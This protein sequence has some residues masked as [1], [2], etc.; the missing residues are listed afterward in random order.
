M[1][2]WWNRFDRVT[3]R[4]DS[5]VSLVP[6]TLH[7]H[8]RVVPCRR[9]TRFVHWIRWKVTQ[10]WLL[11]CVDQLP[12]IVHTAGMRDPNGTEET[13]LHFG[14]LVHLR[15]S[16]DSKTTIQRNKARQAIL[17]VLWP[18]ALR[19]RLLCVSL[20]KPSLRCDRCVWVDRSVPSELRTTDDEHVLPL[21]AKRCVTI[22]VNG[23]MRCGTIGRDITC[24]ISWTARRS[25]FSWSMVESRRLWNLSAS[26]WTQRVEII[27]S[28]DGWSFQGDL[29]SFVVLPETTSLTIL[30]RLSSCLAIHSPSPSL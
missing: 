2:Y 11:R 6:R 9:Q 20:R 7:E 13:F 10:G 5:T 21:C 15:C 3:R 25:C 26:S 29:P 4:Y 8:R 18:R 19:S 30:D 22:T 16:I 27:R 23:E 12:D 14:N 1:L 24:S 17:P 28:T